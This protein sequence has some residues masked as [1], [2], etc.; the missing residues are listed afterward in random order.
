[1]GTVM[2]LSLMAITI[3]LSTY[4]MWKAVSALPKQP[5]FGQP[6]QNSQDADGHAFESQ[7]SS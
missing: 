1:M 2:L 7:R 3:A 4:F 5:V 6:N